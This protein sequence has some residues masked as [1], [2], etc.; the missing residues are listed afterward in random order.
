MEKN[1]KININPLMPFG[2]VML[3]ATI[4]DYVVDNYNKYCDV[5]M[6]NKEKLK[7][8]D[9]SKQLIKTHGIVVKQFSLLLRRAIGDDFL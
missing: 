2:P 6:A 4:P 8:N 5:V 1:T 9:H 7:S 3:H